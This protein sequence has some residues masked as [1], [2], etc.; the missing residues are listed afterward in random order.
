MCGIF[1]LI[2]KKSDLFLPENYLS[3]YLPLITNRGP[4]DQCFKV[5]NQEEN[6]IFLAHSRLAIQDLTE[7]SRQPFVRYSSPDKFLVY[8]GEIYNFASLIS[9]CNSF[10]SDTAALY[11]FLQTKSPC[12]AQLD[13]IFSFAYL[14]C[15]NSTLSLVRDRF[16]T[17]PL[18]YYNDD[19]YLVFSS[20]LR[21]LQAALPSS[22]SINRH[23]VNEVLEYGYTHDLSTIFTGVYKVPPNSI[24]DINLFDFKFSISPIHTNLHRTN[25]SRPK[26]N[27]PDIPLSDLIQDT[28]HQQI[29]NSKRGTGIFLS[30]GIDSTLLVSKA[31]DQNNSLPI[32]TFSSFVYG[33]NTDESARIN[34]FLSYFPD[35]S[36]LTSHF[37]RFN[38]E[39]LESILDDFKNLDYPVLDL[40]ILPFMHLCHSIPSHFKVLLSGDGADEIFLGYKRTFDSYIRFKLIHFKPIYLL[41]SILS[42]FSLFSTFKRYLSVKYPSDVRNLLSGSIPKN[43]RPQQGLDS[44]TQLAHYDIQYYL[45]SVL[46]KVDAASMLYSKEVRVPYLSNKIVDYAFATPL[47]RLS[48]WI[49]PKFILKNL[50]KKYTSPDF[51]NLDKKGFSFDDESLTNYVDDYIQAGNLCELPFPVYIKDR[52]SQTRKNLLLLWLQPFLL[53]SARIN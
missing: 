3:S 34:R 30:G 40:S 4:D 18:F 29:T 51:V 44:F 15:E 14:D 52:L 41:L 24:C 22:L 12:L 31:L 38:Y 11:S 10:P 8:N 2:V 23:Y 43:L 47:S 33:K 46:E 25:T 50:L 21:L 5:I 16:G 7:E 37:Y 45:P 6:Q 39:A 13:G 19:D 42:R 35:H 36:R 49:R 48:N 1:G 27:I 9:D 26:A 32:N 53:E 28:L 17:K 20:S